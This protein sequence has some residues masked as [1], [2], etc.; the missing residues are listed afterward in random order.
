MTVDPG[1]AEGFFPTYLKVSSTI[2]PFGHELPVGELR[3][4]FE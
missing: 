3:F 2:I 4:G 1:K